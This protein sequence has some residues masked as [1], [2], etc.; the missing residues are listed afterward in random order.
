MFINKILKV[1][2]KKSFIIDIRKELIFKHLV[3]V[4]KKT[5]RSQVVD[6]KSKDSSFFTESMKFH[7]SKTSS[8]IQFNFNT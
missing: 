1:V 8:R 7:N 4:C 5:S 6:E 2:R 3:S